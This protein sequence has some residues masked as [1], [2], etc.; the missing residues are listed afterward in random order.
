[1]EQDK[2]EE[3]KE[4]DPPFWEWIVAAVGAVAL[5]ACT[6]YLALD[7]FAAPRTAPS[8]QV[9]AEAIA[10]S[11]GSDGRFAVRVAVSNA[12][13]MPV[14]ELKVV[15]ELQPPQGEPE[16]M[17]TVLPYLPGHSE[18][19]ATFYFGSDPGAGTLRLF[20]ESGQKP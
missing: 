9:K 3:K 5:V 4:Q 17:D 2:K 7:A 19:H 1:M 10:R 20:A 18:R 8:P 11:P 12:G 13:S 16:R 6:G 14:S 15:A